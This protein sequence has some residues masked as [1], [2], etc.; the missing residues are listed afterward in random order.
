M[1]DKSVKSKKCI[2]ES[3]KD[4][5]KNTLQLVHYKHKSVNNNIMNMVS[6]LA[7][8]SFFD[9]IPQVLQRNYIES[10]SNKCCFNSTYFEHIFILIL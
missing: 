3:I 2:I 5:F 9:N 8:L 4:L 10:A 1:W 7:A 6:A